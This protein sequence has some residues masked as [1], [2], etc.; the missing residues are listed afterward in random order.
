MGPTGTTHRRRRCESLCT[1]LASETAAN[2]FLQERERGDLRVV[3][4]VYVVATASKEQGLVHTLH[5]LLVLLLLHLGNWGPL[6]FSDK[7]MSDSFV[8]F[9]CCHPGAWSVTLPPALPA[10]HPLCCH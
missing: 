8:F 5:V 9:H 4:V 10:S 6:V 3:C 7:E 2:D 1:L